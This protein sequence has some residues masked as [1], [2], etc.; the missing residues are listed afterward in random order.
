MAKIYKVFD[1]KNNDSFSPV[2]RIKNS[3]FWKLGLACLLPLLL[4]LAILDAYAV[5]MLKK[6]YLAAAYDRMESLV[7]VALA[8]FPSDEGSVSRENW[9]AWIAGGGVRATLISADGEVLADSESNPAEM[10]NHGDRPEV[11]EAF[12][13][14][15][16]RATRGSVTV[17]NELV[18]LARRFD[19]G[20]SRMLALRLS[21]PLQRLDE[22][23]RAY[24][25]R[26]WGVA[27]GLLALTGGAALFFFR[28][29][30]NRIRRLR[31]F[32]DRVAGGDFRPMPAESRDDELS[33]L[34]DTL[35]RTAARLDGT[36][37]ALTGEREQSAAI[38]S[39][40]DEGVVVVDSNENVIFCNQ[41]FRQAV[42]ASGADYTGRPFIELAWHLDIEHLFQNTLHDGEI[43]RGEA[44]TG[45]TRQGNYAV[46]TAPIRSE[47]SISGAVM[48]LHDISEI[49][50]LERVR[51]DFVANVSHEFR[52]PLSIIQGFAETLLDGAL[53]DAENGRRFTNII[54]DQSLRLSRLTDDL[55][56]LAQIE[57]GRFGAEFRSIDA[58][59]ILESCVES[60]R[61]LISSE[62]KSMTLELECPP[63]LPPLHADVRSIEEIMQN[64]LGNAIRYT[65]GGGR[66]CVKAAI[67]D[68]DMV[69]SVSDTG[70]GLSSADQ[71]RVFERFYRTDAA[72]SR[73]SGGTGLGL[74]IVKHLVENH[75]GRV[76]LESQIGIGSTFRVFLPLDA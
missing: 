70:I 71:Q 64:L 40:M 43:M 66:V 11:R 39:S 75:G 62:Q 47:D 67:T 22:S 38:L 28:A 42:G 48:V 32:S 25:S 57:S 1:M 26:Q 18:Y 33:A 55:L 36:I 65:P 69:L 45:F 9:T 50:R 30:S 58:R 46:T 68:G 73:E 21:V 19:A 76:E 3:I 34:S 27:L 16:G 13:N 7:E 20:N 12:M 10:E 63:S 8:R 49:R 6:E 44:T 2:R 53:E 60:A 72:R 14:G 35:N 23:V 31:E 54:H 5:R 41:S 37:R 17:H 24:R 56:K 74:S 59:P 29:L 61:A 15:S 51:R 52:T 4:T